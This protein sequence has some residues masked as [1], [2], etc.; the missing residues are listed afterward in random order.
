MVEDLCERALALVGGRGEAVVTASRGQAALTRFANGYIHQNVTESVVDVRITVA[1]GG[2]V[3]RSSTNRTDDEGLAAAVERAL[4]AAALRPADP[5]FPGFAPPAEVP[6]VDHRDA[7]TAEATPADR[8]EVVA[9]FVAAGGGTG[10]AG[11]GAAGYCATRWRCRALLATTGQR[12]TTRSTVARLDGVRR[13][14]TSDGL[15]HATSTA[16]ATI[17]GRACGEGAVARA[18][19][20]VGPV[21]LP[22]GTY[23]VV[24]EPRAVAAVLQ[25]PAMGFGGKARAEGTSF[26][27][28]GRAQWDAA[29]DIWD[30]ATDAR[31]LG[32]PFD[33]EGTPKRRLDLVRE[34]VSVGLAHDRR[35]AARAGV[36]PTGHAVGSD[37][38]GGRPTDLFMGGGDR[39]PGDLVGDVDRGLLVADLWYNRILDPRTQVVTG[40]TRN[41]LFLIE[42][43]RLAAP[44]QD[45]RFTQSVVEAFGPGRVLGLGDDARLVGGEG[46]AAHVPSV[47]LAGW[48]FTGNA[49]G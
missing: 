4:A 15:G 25:F 10:G 46:A 17:D 42:E 38:V 27:R 26:V 5:A 6:G 28:L 21:E 20:G 33:A 36:A 9:A 16:L 31:A 18:R 40:V 48:A 37:V 22:P 14:G 7:A 8:A 49:R 3:A 12:A 41:G 34:G 45:L 44:V 23:E 30:D 35:S 19:A 13:V 32:D 2:R 1:A 47:H 29:V 39:P 24:L 43:G 11:P